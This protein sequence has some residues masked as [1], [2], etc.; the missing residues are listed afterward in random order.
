MKLS[1]NNYKGLHL[2]SINIT[3]FGYGEEE[4]RK[5]LVEDLE[6]RSSGVYVVTNP[7]QFFKKISGRISKENTG[8][9]FY[10]IF[11]QDCEIVL[12][13]GEW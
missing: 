4:F 13:S 5:E 12:Y 7:K 8:K 11:T 10:Y 1:I 2:Q 9:L 3:F 6:R